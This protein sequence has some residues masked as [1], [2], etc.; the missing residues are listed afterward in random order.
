MT[1]NLNNRLKI[2]SISKLLDS[3]TVNYEDFFLKDSLIE[4][5]SLDL[6]KKIQIALNT[7]D[8]YLCEVLESE[9][10]I[11]SNEKILYKIDDLII[12]EDKEYVDIKNL[13]KYPIGENIFWISLSC[14]LADIEKFNSLYFNISSNK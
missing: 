1:I 6:N 5:K 8:L 7:T 4:I 11:K 3:L 10:G 14:T 9:N 2:G 12:Y 13:K